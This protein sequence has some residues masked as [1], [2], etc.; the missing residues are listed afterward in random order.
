M[1]DILNPTQRSYCMSRIRGSG[2][3]ATELRLIRLF[4]Q[5]R[6]IGWRRNW[7][8]FGKPDFVFPARR[9]AIFVDGEFWHGHPTRA[10][11]PVTNRAFWI[12]K[13]ERNRKRDLLVKRTLSA[14]G[15][16]VIRIWQRDIAKAGTLKRIFT[17]LGKASL[18]NASRTIP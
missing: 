2:N 18:S 12:A 10:N 15:W 1:A 13:I 4:Q 5:N 9:L 8:L 7:P 11:I 16:T 14:S 6:I 3:A 17:A